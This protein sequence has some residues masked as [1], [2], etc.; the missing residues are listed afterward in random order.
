MS[1]KKLFQ[2]NKS[3]KVVSNYLK[4]TSPDNVGGGIES[5]GHLSES[6]KKQNK[7]VPN[8]D[9]GD[10]KVFA[11]F[12]SAEKYYE[13]A[14]VYTVNNY[15]YD[16]S[17]FE[18]TEFFNN[19]NPLEQYV[20]ENKYPKTT[21]FV[22][23]GTA[24][25]T[26]T[27]GTSHYFSA[28]KEEYIQI[29]GGPHSGTVFSTASYR[30]NN[31]EFGGPSGSTVE[32]FLSKSAIPGGGAV[33]TTQSPKQVVLDVWN[34]A[35]TGTFN[36]TSGIGYGRLR[37]ELSKS[38][39]DRF[40]VTMQS[41][42]IGYLT[43]SI[44][45]TGGIGSYITGGWN[46]YSFV[47]N[48]TGSSPTIDFYINGTCHETGI[49]ITPGATLDGELGK[50]TGS[51]VAN[52]GALRTPPS[53]NNSA[54]NT[55]V[56]LRGYGKLSGS[57][58]EFRFWKKAR[59][60]EEI[61]RY[62]FTDVNGGSNKYD[63]NVDLG[64][65]YKFNAGITHT[66]S[67]DN[68]VLD[69]SGRISNGNWVG[70]D[71]S[72]YSPRNTGSA[73]D[74]M[75]LTSK[76]EDPTPIVRINNPLYG[77]RLNELTTL[78]QSYDY[79]NNAW[80][81]NS[82]PEWIIEEDQNSSEL[83]AIT[84]IM[85]SYFD[86][87][88]TQIS[89][90]SKIKNMKYLSGSST[91]SINEFPHNDRLIE[92]LG[93]EV[94]ALFQD[95]GAMQDLLNRDEAI[96]FQQNLEVIKNTIYRN[97]YNN[98]QDILKSKG[99]NKAFRNLLRCF[100]IDENIV[101]LNVYGTNSD[102]DLETNYK[103][104]TSNKK[105]IDFSGLSDASSSVATVYQ[106]YDS[107]V[108]GSSG[109]ISGSSG[110]VAGCPELEQS[111]FTI[112]CEALFPLSN[113]GYTPINPNTLTVESSLFGWHSPADLSSSNGGVDT[114]W[115]GSLELDWG[116]QVSAIKSASYYSD[117]T[118]DTSLLR[119]ACFRV[120]NR[121]GD[122]VLTS[123]VFQGV[124]DNQKWN[125]S[126][127]IRPAKYGIVS[128]AAPWSDALTN[129][130]EPGS[131]Q[132][133]YILEFYG[134]NYDSGIKRDSFYLTSSLT[135][136]AD[137]KNAMS[138]FSG[139]S[140]VISKKRLYMGAHRQNFTGTLLQ[141]SDAKI[142]SLR[143]WTDRIPSGTVDLHAREVDSWGRVNP[144]KEAYEWQWDSPNVFLPKIDTLALNWDFAN[145]TA[146]NAAGEFSVTDFSSGSNVL[147]AIERSAASL[148]YNPSDLRQGALYG[149]INLQKHT[150]KGEF[151]SGLSAPA[152]KQFIYMDKKS[153]PEYASS[154]DMVKVLDSDTQVFKTGLRPTNYYFSVEKSMYQ[155]I[156]NS[157]LELFASIEEM[158]NL[159]GDPVNRYRPNYKSMEKLREI[160]FRRVGNTPDLQKYLEYYKW[161][162]MSIGQMIEQLFPASSKAAPGIRTMVESHV[163]ERPKYRHH[164][165]GPQKYS[166]NENG[167]DAGGNMRTPPIPFPQNALQA[168]GVVNIDRVGNYQGF[169]GLKLAP[170][171]SAPGAAQNQS[172]HSFWW[173]TKADR[174]NITISSS[175]PG[176]MATRQ[177][178]F[179]QLT[180][181]P[182]PSAS[183]Y[184]FNVTR[185][186]SL[187]LD[188]GR[189]STKTNKIGR[190][191]PGLIKLSFGNFEEEKH[192]TDII[193]PNLKKRRTYSSSF[194]GTNYNG[195]LFTP[196]TAISSSVDTGYQA[197]LIVQSVKNVDLANL[198]G[199]AR[200]LQGPFTLAH[201]GGLQARSV[202]PLTPGGSDVSPYSRKES[203][204]LVIENG[205]GQFSLH[206]TSEIPKGQY[207]R[208]A[209]ISS[210]VN[211]E[212]IKTSGTLIEPHGGV[213]LLTGGVSVIG[214]YSKNYEV[215]F[216]QNRSD[217]NMDFV[218]NTKNYY[219]AS[220]ASGSM[221]S[222]FLT[223]PG[224]RSLNR[225][226][227]VDYNTP[228]E[229]GA[230]LGTLRKTKSV[231]VQ[232]FAAP[233]SKKD[234][235]AQFRDV[236]SDQFSPNN[237]LPFR[238]IPVRED[239]AQALSQ[240]VSWGG[241]TG[242]SETI[243]NTYGANTTQGLKS[244]SALDLLN[245]GVERF[246]FSSGSIYLS[247][248]AFSNGE[249]LTLS[250][251]GYDYS[252]TLDNTV[253]PASSTATV[254]GISG[255]SSTS[256]DASFALAIMN[257]LITWA[258]QGGGSLVIPV[259][260]GARL[261][262][263]PYNVQITRMTHGSSADGTAFGGTLVG[264][265]GITFGAFSADGLQQGVGGAALYGYLTGGV[266]QNSKT[267][268]NATKRI[269][270]FSN[271][272]SWA[273]NIQSYYT[274]S[275]FDN[276]YVVRPI[277]EAD[278][279]NWFISLS[280]SQSSLE[281]SGGL[282]Y[283]QY[284]MSGSRYPA[285][286]TF[287]SST[288]S[289]EAGESTRI[290]F[291]YWYNCRRQRGCS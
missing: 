181:Y 125:F 16:G 215:V 196:F 249:T 140:M 123:P 21:G 204:N 264:N 48:T 139:S 39:E 214:N 157:M 10:P 213:P 127:G 75:S 187:L 155:G 118:M 73:I 285:N 50:V 291:L 159:I 69:Y 254:I 276:A 82:F 256:A 167:I 266:N 183:A 85:S 95:V 109:V 160:F 12:G 151:F 2:D 252:A 268:R 174:N 124:Y 26:A 18:K 58:D 219:T 40:Y 76:I 150:G 172:E 233:G 28:S 63:A 271:Q 24:Y 57:L 207:L 243:M 89:E 93:I 7:F 122:L 104:S 83:K 30:T 227:T 44:P 209:G 288:L 251:D 158:N 102:Y 169:G 234:S 228:R 237:A 289:S 191:N 248:A 38:T 15:P 103:T 164:F 112:E 180:N 168:G 238:N 67:T 253:S 216:T 133:S 270:L 52:L 173:K 71:A 236:P 55:P 13:N 147:A 186:S 230:Q 74:H 8:L 90:I 72:T 47:F 178:I 212:N 41:G 111:A 137:I 132:A 240:H 22:E 189:N 260:I 145:I 53:G 201:V 226:G 97:I 229:V 263:A 5:A 33:V 223:P 19:L 136:A 198:H 162:D 106:Y 170:V 148:P 113:N 98:L 91:G 190:D 87:L 287:V 25:G 128:G 197:E 176:I 272:G 62:W 192:S 261:A 258:Y 245:S 250:L 144:Y 166:R 232:R 99:T 35:P 278:R 161:I 177:A 149:R 146:S 220:L 235:K 152:K 96:V 92:N 188:I 222:A 1:I 241:F 225:S 11:K 46:Q 259:S 65:Y 279:T 78:G 100:G 129:Y 281:P 31:L 193:V 20:F 175:D 283:E 165:V 200:T 280:G 265:S 206:E 143:Y 156:S 182:T 105:Y 42:A 202:P 80:L 269:K 120:T 153:L 275:T 84:Q 239:L 81:M 242:S 135:G 273:E 60:G 77:A 17:G 284:V 231:L 6:I 217:T 257:S 141:S 101:S 107:G 255:L 286:I 49:S 121:S 27:S 195:E 117:S 290:S 79:Q 126:V 154:N 110:S 86:T 130:E 244:V 23:L 4:N 274:A 51:L 14:F 131:G 3:G 88:S 32:F 43:Q 119:D 61:G 210:P 114:T 267:Q 184:R 262:S 64:V 247:S 29:Q 205:T 36:T 199:R 282:N 194:G 115:T 54:T 211:I 179:Q 34:G 94:G 208:G 224:M 138:Y 203:Y 185:D 70:Y 9:Y 221:P 56:P 116:L 246:G 66:S 37:I 108:T 218:F 134:V 171:P 68:I 277:P 45:T 142:S 59:N 163:L